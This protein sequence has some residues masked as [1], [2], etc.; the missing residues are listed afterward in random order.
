[1]AALYE[2]LPLPL[3]FGAVGGFAIAA[4]LMLA[5]FVKPA[6]RLMGGVR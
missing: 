3:L 4:G 1:M 2:A 5:L 6:V